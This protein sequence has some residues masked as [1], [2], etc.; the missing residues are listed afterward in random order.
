MIQEG[1]KSEVDYLQICFEDNGIGFNQK[2]G[3][4]I[5]ELFKRLHNRNEYSGTGIGLAIVKKIVDNHDGF[6]SAESDEQKGADFTIL[7]PVN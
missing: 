5:F 1:I 6:I 3:E 4:K 7:L 2:D